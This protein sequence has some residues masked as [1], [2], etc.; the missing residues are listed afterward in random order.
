MQ[1]VPP[2]LEPGIRQPVEPL[3]LILAQSASRQEGRLLLQ[4]L[5]GAA[6]TLG[7]GIARCISSPGSLL[8]CRTTQHH[9]QAATAHNM[10]RAGRGT[11]KLPSLTQEMEANV[12]RPPTHSSHLHLQTLA[13]GGARHSV[14]VT[15]LGGDRAQHSLNRLHAKHPT[16]APAPCA[17]YVHPPACAAALSGTRRVPLAPPVLP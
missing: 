13:L 15:P 17:A 8:Q 14:C 16:G 6:S 10:V 4:L 12:A 3:Q 9:T 11:C 2:H 1:G 5:E 7:D